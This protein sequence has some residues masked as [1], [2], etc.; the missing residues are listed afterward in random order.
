MIIGATNP[1]K[2]ERRGPAEMARERSTQG[3]LGR[4]ANSPAHTHSP[5]WQEAHTA[6]C[7]TSTCSL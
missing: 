5:D 1:P 6:H 2:T 7:H 3:P 4:E